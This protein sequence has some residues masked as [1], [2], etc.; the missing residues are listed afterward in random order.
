METKLCLT[1]KEIEEL[2]QVNKEK[3]LEITRIETTLTEVIKKLVIAA[4]FIEKQ[5]EQCA[6]LRTCAMKKTRD[7]DKM[8][9]ELK[10][11]STQLENSR[12]EN[13]NLHRALLAAT[14][15]LTREKQRQFSGT[16]LL[17]DGHGR[18]SSESSCEV[19]YFP[20]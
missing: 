3:G 4:S 2:T 11:F 17:K 12:N 1:K 20:P 6:N 13:A 14:E 18:K 9:D 19:R 16:E 8:Q 15:R 5:N 7:G 10:R